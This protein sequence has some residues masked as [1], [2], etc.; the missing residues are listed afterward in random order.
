MQQQRVGVVDDVQEVQAL[1]HPVRIA[2]LAAL[3]SPDSAAGVA[4]AIGHSRQL[5]NYHL[6]ELERAGLIVAAGERR[7]GNFVEQLYE[8]VASTFVVSPRLAWGG[9]DRDRAIRDQ[10]SLEH[11]I[12]LGERLQRDAGALLDRAAFDGE[13][14]ASAT[15]EADVR[16][17][18]E[19]ARS[20]FMTEYLAVL[21][22]LLKKHG[23]KRGL[24][25]R[26]AMAVYPDTEE[27]K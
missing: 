9:A 12:T 14:I 5:V 2:A 15:V 4:R 25:H 6:K 21:G 1:T 8:A 13:Q 17:A 3:R 23:A 7:K 19:A 26:V 24:R 11:L 20:A 10:A 16:F 27:N 22:P 18:D